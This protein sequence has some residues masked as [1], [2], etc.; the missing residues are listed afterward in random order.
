[1][2][3]SQNIRKNFIDIVSDA[4]E[5]QG[6]STGDEL[7]LHS[8]GPSSVFCFSIRTYAVAG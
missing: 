6:H 7:A 2:Q 3:S 5:Q 4:A 1:M 8:D